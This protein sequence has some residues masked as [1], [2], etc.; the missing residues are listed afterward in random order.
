[1]NK[2]RYVL[3]MVPAG[4]PVQD[5]SKIR[6]KS[7]DFWWF[8]NRFCVRDGRFCSRLRQNAAFVSRNIWRKFPAII[9]EKIPT[10]RKIWKNGGSGGPDFDFRTDITSV[11]A[12]F[13][14]DC[15]KML[16][17]CRGTSGA[18]FRNFWRKNSNH[19][20]NPKNGGSGDG[21]CT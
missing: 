7:V 16:L 20:E 21:R 5:P 17:S 14:R 3:K 12:D 1:M 6:P 19:S 11:T 4:G 18:N 13:A 2:R 8:S 9:G 15:G 10:I